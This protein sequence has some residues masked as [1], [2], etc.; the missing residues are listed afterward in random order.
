MFFSSF[1][2]ATKQIGHVTPPEWFTGLVEKQEDGC[3]YF[4]VSGEGETQELVALG[5]SEQVFGKMMELSDLSDLYGDRKDQETLEKAVQG[6]YYPEE[7]EDVSHHQE[8]PLTLVQSEWVF[9]NDFHGFF[10]YF[11]IPSDVVEKLEDL[12]GRRVFR[13]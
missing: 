1:S 5:V 11:C 6:L 10:G 12:P 13:G 3:F 7:R 9:E 2:C 4:P 8:I